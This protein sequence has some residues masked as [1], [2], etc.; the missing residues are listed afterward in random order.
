MVDFP[1]LIQFFKLVFYS[2]MLQLTGLG[3]WVSWY[4]LDGWFSL[5]TW[6]NRSVWFSN[7]K[8][9]NKLQWFTFSFCYISSVWLTKS[10]WCN[11]ALSVLEKVIQFNNWAT[12]CSDAMSSRGLLDLYVTLSSTGCLLMDDA[13]VLVGNLSISVSILIYGWLLFN[14]TFPIWLTY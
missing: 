11:F 12:S 14:A 8:R 5:L 7:L 6:C 13:V 1:L 4:N 10:R 9:Y 2:L 3:V